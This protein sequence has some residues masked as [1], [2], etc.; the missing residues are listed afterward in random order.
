MASLLLVSGINDYYQAMRAV[1]AGAVGIGFVFH[2]KQ[3]INPEKAREI[4]LA[5]PPL[6]S[7]VGFFQDEPW[8]SVMEIVTLCA[9]EVVA[10]EG[11]EDAGYLKRFSQHV[12]KYRHLPG[13]MGNDYFS[14][15]DYSRWREGMDNRNLFIRCE[16][17]RDKLQHVQ[18]AIRPFG[19]EVRVSSEEEL[20]KLLTVMD[21]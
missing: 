15:I 20:R 2:G 3:A 10:F 14:I 21:N 7:R 19:I 6:V 5:L 1:Q 12:L 11:K 13:E 18:K 16:P 9:L 17:E 8:Y 4:A